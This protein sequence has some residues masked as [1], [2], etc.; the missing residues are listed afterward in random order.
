MPVSLEDQATLV[1]LFDLVEHDVEDSHKIE[2]PHL[3][4]GLGDDNVVF[5]EE[6]L[7]LLLEL[8]AKFAR[9][10]LKQRGP[11]P[12]AVEKLLIEACWIAKDQNAQKALRWLDSALDAPLNRW[13]VVQHIQVLLPQ[14][15]DEMK[16]GSCEIKR[17]LPERAAMADLRRLVRDASDLRAPIVVC[18]VLAK[19]GESARRLADEK[20]DETLAVINML[21]RTMDGR[22]NNYLSIVDSRAT[23]HHQ[24]GRMY[25]IEKSDRYGALY[26]RYV[27]LA[28]AASRPDDERTEWERRTLIAA[29]WFRRASEALWPSEALAALMISLECIFVPEIQRGNKREA[30]ATGLRVQGF[31]TPNMTSDEQYQWIKALYGRRNDVVHAGRGFLEDLEVVRLNQLIESVLHWSIWH[32]SPHH[33]VDGDA[34]TSFA[35]V[36]G[37]HRI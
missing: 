7:R 9:S 13:T 33:R 3:V 25:L 17:T 14:N 5:R 21:G 10:A 24:V 2:G 1:R 16:I 36:M 28:G 20:I 26:P 4:S 6:G 35:E 31:K 32:L 22:E 11:L 19:D 34:C 37:P 12:N 29:R 8:Q 18:E 23:L 27:D 30:I 15:C